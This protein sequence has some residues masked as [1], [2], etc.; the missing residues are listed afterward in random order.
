M[1]QPSDDLAMPQAGSVKATKTPKPAS[2]VSNEELMVILEQNTFLLEENFKL[3]RRLHANMIF[4]QVM[5]WVKFLIIV[6][7]LALV[8]NYLPPMFGQLVGAYQKL[9]PGG[10]VRCLPSEDAKNSVPSQAIQPEQPIV[11]PVSPTT[12]TSTVQ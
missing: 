3:T 9:Q 1:P 12:S 10:L 2:A 7:S 11:I 4:A 5:F 6:A 8:F